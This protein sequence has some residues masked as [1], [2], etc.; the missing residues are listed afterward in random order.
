[1][2]YR[3][4][5]LNI[6][7]CFPLK[8]RSVIVSKSFWYIIQMNVFKLCINL[9]KN[10]LSR[11]V[12]RVFNTLMPTLHQTLKPS[13]RRHCLWASIHLVHAASP[14]STIHSSRNFLVSGHAQQIF[15]FG[16]WSCSEALVKTSW[17]FWATV[18]FPYERS[19]LIITALYR[20]L[21]KWGHKE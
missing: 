20:S 18:M 14:C 5:Y 15:F 12:W 9:R 4:V 21:Y 8:N 1:M 19:L 3:D 2:Q 7:K 11:K 16:F 17:F 10:Y 6:K 13:A